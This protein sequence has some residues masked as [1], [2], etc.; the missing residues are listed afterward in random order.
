MSRKGFTLIE[1]LV[2]VAVL[3]LLA[4]IVTSNLGGAREGARISNALSFQSQTH[5]LLGSDLIAWWNFNEGSGDI[6]GDTSGYGNHGNVVG[7]G[8]IWSSTEKP[9]TEVDYSYK[10][11]GG[12]Y[13]NINND[14]GVPIQATVTFWF[15]VTEGDKTRTQYFMDGRNGGN[16]WFLQSYNPNDSGN[17]N[18]HGRAIVASEDW[19]ADQWNH[20]VLVV[21]PSYSRI[22]INS[23]LMAQGSGLSFQLGEDLRIGTRYTDS[24]RFRGNLTDIRIYERALSSV[25]IMELYAETKD[26]YLAND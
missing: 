3:A 18:F 15:Y 12:Q 5:S 6:V 22:Y 19:V 21:N 13:V 4:S 25:E 20:L 9:H 16:W 17:I 11:S 10:F 23:T 8:G 14:L 7:S 26:N 24:G 1:L 2:V